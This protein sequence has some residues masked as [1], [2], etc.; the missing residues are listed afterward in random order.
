LIRRDGRLRW[1][2]DG[3]IHD[4]NTSHSQ[5]L[6]LMTPPQHPPMAMAL[7]RVLTR[8]LGR[9]ARPMFRWSLS[10]VE[11]TETSG[12]DAFRTLVEIE[13]K[14][15]ACR[16]FPHALPPGEQRV[17]KGRLGGRAVRC[18]AGSFCSS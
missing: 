1:R 6:E 3:A 4:S 14:C 5:H 11:A 2:V 16:R 8:C 18:G 13:D 9:S 10:A 12:F 7:P 15:K 17:F